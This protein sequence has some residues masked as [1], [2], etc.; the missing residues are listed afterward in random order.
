MKSGKTNLPNLAPSSP[1]DGI[2]IETVAINTIEAVAFKRQQKEQI[3]RIRTLLLS[4]NFKE[5]EDLL[6]ELRRRDEEFHNSSNSEIEQTSYIEKQGEFVTLAPTEIAQFVGKS[7]SAL[8]NYLIE[9]YGARVPDPGHM[10]YLF[11][12]PEQVPE[13]EIHKHYYFFGSKPRPKYAGSDATPSLFL[14]GGIYGDKR[15][16]LKDT[17]HYRLGGKWRENER[18]LLLKQ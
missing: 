12:H 16:F 13:L 14:R 10:E 4:R 18:V 5:A 15:E 17:P 6:K 2:E 1:A 9:K 7:R 3:N 11:K 8:Q